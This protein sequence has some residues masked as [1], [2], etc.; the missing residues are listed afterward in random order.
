MNLSWT[1]ATG[2]DHLSFYGKNSDIRERERWRERGR[3][4]KRR[5][6]REHEGEFW[7]AGGWKKSW[8]NAAEK[9]SIPTIGT[10]GWRNAGRD[11]VKGES[12]RE[13]EEKGESIQ[14][15]QMS[16]KA[17]EGEGERGWERG[18]SS[19]IIDF[20]FHFLLT[21]LALIKE[22]SG[23]HPVAHAFSHSLTHSPTHLLSNALTHTLSSHP[24]RSLSLSLSL[25]HSLSPFLSHSRSHFLTLTLPFNLSHLLSHSITQICLLLCS[26]FSSR[27]LIINQVQKMIE[28]IQKKGAHERE[29]IDSLSL[30]LSLSLWMK[31]MQA[32]SEIWRLVEV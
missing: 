23:G 6:E 27:V 17:W 14:K 31:M 26:S 25:F 10:S 30:S 2:T 20:I 4:R 32:G 1:F 21:E 3:E 18:H 12:E 7:E 24:F 28:K 22:P 13:R 16:E 15:Q 29:T 9:K 19:S 5:I 11:R 8:E